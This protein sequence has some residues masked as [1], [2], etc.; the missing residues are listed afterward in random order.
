[1]C[2]RK[3]RIWYLWLTYH[4]YIILQVKHYYYIKIKLTDIS[5]SSAGFCKNRTIQKQNHH[6]NFHYDIRVALILKSH[7]LNLFWKKIFFSRTYGGQSRQMTDFFK[8]SFFLYFFRKY[9][10]FWMKL[11]GSMKQENMNE[12]MG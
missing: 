10:Y 5:F 3:Y 8:N 9:R 1:M 7:P 4:V 6:L 11:L 2:L 12:I